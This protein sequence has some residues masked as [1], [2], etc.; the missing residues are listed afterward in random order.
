M[1]KIF[2]LEAALS[3]LPSI[4]YVMLS[5]LL[6]GRL[7]IQHFMI[8]TSKGH[9]QFSGENMNKFLS[10]KK[11][12]DH[13]LTTPITQQGGELLVLPCGQASTGSPDYQEL[14]EAGNDDSEDEDSMGT[15][16]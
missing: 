5:T 15:R 16:L 10:L 12:L 2:I 13:H 6:I 8:D 14:F 1:I 4:Y 11:L 9:Y 3:T 7:G